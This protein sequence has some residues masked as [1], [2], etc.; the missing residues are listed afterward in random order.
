MEKRVVFSFGYGSLQTGFPAVMARFWDAENPHPMQFTAAL[1]AAPDIPDT[2]RAWQILYRA[3][4]HRLDWHPRIDIEAADVTNVSEAQFE[5]LCQGLAQQINSWLSSA[6]FQPIDQ[7]LRT[8]LEPADDICLVIE[9]DDELLQRLPWHLWRLFEDYPRAE[10]T[11]SPPNYQRVSRESSQVKRDRV[12]I[13]VVLGNADGIDV[14]RDRALLSQLS[15][16]ADIT[17]LTEPS[18]ETLTQAL[19]QGCDLF[20]FAGHSSSQAADQTTHEITSQTSSQTGGQLRLNAH[21]QLTIEQLKYALQGAISTG[22]KLAIFNSCDGLALARSLAA[23]NIPQVIVMREPVPDRAAQAFLSHF[24]N[25]FA[26]DYTLYRAVRAAREHLQGLE[27]DYPCASWLPAI[28]QNPATA[29]TSWRQWPSSS[30]VATRPPAHST[31]RSARRATP[32]GECLQVITLAG[33]LATAV[34]AG[35]R[36]LGWL[37]SAELWAF[38]RLMRLRP[39]ERPDP[40]LLLITITEEDF[41]LP[42]QAQRKGSLS[43]LALAQVLQKLDS[44]QPGAIG[45]DIYRDFPA[46]LAQHDLGERLGEQDNLYVICKGS[47]RTESVGIAPPPEVPPERQGFSDVVKDPDNVLRRHLIAMNPL[48]ASPCSTPYAL[49]TQ[50]AFSYLN[51][52]GHAIEYTP[53]GELWIGDVPIKA[54]KPASG[55]YQAVDTWGYQTLLNYRATP[56]TSTVAATVTLADV[57][58]DRLQPEQI[59]DRIVLIG[60]SAASAGDF[61]STP[62]SA[63][64]TAYRALPGVMVQAHMISQLLSAVEN[65]RPLLNPWPRA[66]EFIWIWVWAT[67]GSGLA[68]YWRPGGV[69]VLTAIIAL[70]SLFAACLWL[71]VSGIWAPLIPAGLAFLLAG[72]STGLYLVFVERDRSTPLLKASKPS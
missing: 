64:P 50:L 66:T 30:S 32:L 39:S 34:V 70:G 35:G 33:L 67:V 4:H 22:L 8:Y 6:E 53:D 23:L 59:K 15:N 47:D 28:Y 9:T 12:K 41:Q 26:Q 54:L 7:P 40:R 31:K 10:A 72:G 17:T 3:M 18:L 46:E 25:A 44:M 1:P 56:P 51:A 20:F 48:P 52:A 36:H 57:L 38:D 19:W 63:Q 43:D 55:G 61:F 69:L 37:Q 16:Q 71:L 5:D 2:Y 49:S 11:L 13:L 62:Y 42:A 45:L 65:N 14:E 68:V 24:L 60:V 21:Q 58:S 29:P 27:A